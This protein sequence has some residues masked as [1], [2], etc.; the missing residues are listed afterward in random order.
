MMFRSS[1]NMLG[2]LGGRE[3]CLLDK[4]EPQWL[5]VVMP[6]RPRNPERVLLFLAPCGGGGR[7]GTMARLARS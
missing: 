5:R 2:G 4:G 1:G 6:I 3:A 7:L